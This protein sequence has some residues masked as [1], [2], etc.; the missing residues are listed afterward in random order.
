MM[1]SIRLRYH[2]DATLG[3]PRLSVQEGLVSGEELQHLE[4]EVGQNYQGLIARDG[5]VVRFRTRLKGCAGKRTPFRVTVERQVPRCPTLLLQSISPAP[6]CRENGDWTRGFWVEVY[7][8]L[9]E[10]SRGKESALGSALWECLELSRSG[11]RQLALT[12]L[13]D[14]LAQLAGRAPRGSEAGRYLRAAR[15]LRDLLPPALPRLS[16][17][18][19]AGRLRRLVGWLGSFLCWRRG[20]PVPRGAGGSASPP[21]GL[22]R[23]GDVARPV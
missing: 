17:P 21:V 5:Q 2:L 1:T 23:G 13:A 19:R 10:G 12:L 18:W 15:L 7:A 11:P 16:P 3:R 9:G 14:H 8:A 4:E 20:T 22:R 6:L